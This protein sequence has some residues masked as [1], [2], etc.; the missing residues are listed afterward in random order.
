MIIAKKKVFSPDRI[1]TGRLLSWRAGLSG[2]K[3]AI[4]WLEPFVLLS[5]KLHGAGDGQYA[6]LEASSATSAQCDLK[7]KGLDLA[8]RMNACVGLCTLPE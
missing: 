6:T 7:G 1:T 5:T 8:D 2:G 4:Q 3:Q